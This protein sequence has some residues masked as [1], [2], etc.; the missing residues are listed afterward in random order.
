MYT[1]GMATITDI[2]P[3]AK[4]KGRV[5]LY[6]DDRFYCGLE[7]LTALSCRLTVGDEI[8]PDRLSAAVAESEC[9]SAFEKAAKYL[10]LRPRTER[11]MRTYLEQKGYAAQTVDSTVQKLASYGYVD[12]AEYCRIYVEEYKRKAG[13]RKLEADLREKGVPRRYIEDALAA[14]EDQTDAAAALAEKYLRSHAPDYRKLTAYLLSKGFDY[15]TVKS[16]LRALEQGD[17][18]DE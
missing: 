12:D 10:G 4:N 2:K 6:I 15:D 9:A 5:N 7:K 13:V 3:Q 18:N 14:L 1:I 16:A 8:D 11:E 17:E